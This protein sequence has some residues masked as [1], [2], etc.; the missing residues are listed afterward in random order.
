MGGRVT[1]KSGR[2]VLVAR[3]AGFMA[4][5]TH[6]TVLLAIVRLVGGEWVGAGRTDACSPELR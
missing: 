5:V 6:L 3:H 2:V 4:F 1:S